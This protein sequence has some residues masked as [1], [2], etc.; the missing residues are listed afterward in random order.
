M[1]P[2]LAQQYGER[3]AEAHEAH[4]SAAQIIQDFAEAH[5]LYIDDPARPDGPGRWMVPSPTPH[6][7]RRDGDTLSCLQCAVSVHAPTPPPRPLTPQE[8][9]L[10][11]FD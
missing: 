2:T 6:T 1:R 3:F 5:P 9:S 8:A 4:Y 7:I 10:S 11:R